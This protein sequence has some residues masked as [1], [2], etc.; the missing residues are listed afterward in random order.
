M[1]DSEVRLI[2]GQL[3]LLRGGMSQIE[4]MKGINSG[5]E[6]PISICRNL[7]NEDEDTFISKEAAE[8]LKEFRNRS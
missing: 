7:E 6:T 4:N 8:I 1:D 2:V 3:D 5:N